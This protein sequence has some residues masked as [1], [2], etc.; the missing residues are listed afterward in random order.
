MRVAK[1]TLLQFPTQAAAP[2]SERRARV[3]S[4]AG[5]CWSCRQ[6]FAADTRFCPF[7]GQAL[8]A[9]TDWDP[10]AASLVGTVIDQRY[11]VEELLGEGGVGVVYVVCHTALSKRFALKALRLNLC[12]EPQVAT[13]FVEQARAAVSVRHAGLVEITDVGSLPS[14]QP[15]FVMDHLEGQPLS[16]LLRQTG[17]LPAARVIAIARQIA[18]A[19]RPAHQRGSAHAALKPGNIYVDA[20][21]AL[22]EQITITDFGL[23]QVGASSVLTRPGIIP[24]DPHYMSPEQAAGEAADARSDIY[25]LGAVMYEMLTGCV[26][27]EADVYQDVL[28]LQLNAVPEHPRTFSPQ[29]KGYG[30]LDDIIVRCLEKNPAERYASLGALLEELAAAEQATEPSAIRSRSSFVSSSSLELELPKSSATH[31]TLS[32]ELAE[33]V[34][35]GHPLWLKLAVV[36]VALVASVSVAFA[37]RPKHAVE[38]PV[39]ANVATLPPVLAASSPALSP[40]TATGRAT[41]STEPS[42]AAAGSAAAPGVHAPRPTSAGP[43]QKHAAGRRALKPSRA[44]EIVDPWGK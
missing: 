36:V 1:Q 34:A 26:P 20:S 29:F 4:R 28:D 14:G 2:P 44:P 12:S 10:A 13:R 27:F 9:A 18:E 5:V 35:S 6:R 17:P 19:L 39:A 7:D 37:F 16:Q 30:A 32:D 40:T 3:A 38:R 31:P 8:E 42:S 23:A 43:W 41:P 24:G 11:R 33:P 15:Y 21:L 25:S 22:G